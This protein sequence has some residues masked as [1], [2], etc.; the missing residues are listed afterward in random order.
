MLVRRDVGLRSGPRC[1]DH[2]SPDDLAVP[3]GQ[4][5][6]GAEIADEKIVVHEGAIGY[7]LPAVVLE[8]ADLAVDAP[9]L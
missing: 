3:A 9:G 5:T 7:V 8:D 1:G 6:V 4:Q 2:V